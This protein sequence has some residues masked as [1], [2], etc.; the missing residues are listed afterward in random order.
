MSKGW[1]GRPKPCGTQRGDLTSPGAVQ[2]G[3]RGPQ[4]Q[5][6]WA[7]EWS[8]EARA[9][10]CWRSRPRVG[11]W[12]PSR[13]TQETGSTSPEALCAGVG[14]Q[15]TPTTGGALIPQGASPESVVSSLRLGHPWV[16]A[17]EV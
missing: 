7:F 5:P 11:W 12:E 2:T 15:P 4:N 9:S 6:C 8:L 16:R 14:T 17:G 13:P 10:V 1:A 3:L